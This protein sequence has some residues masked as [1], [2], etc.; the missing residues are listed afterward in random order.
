MPNFSGET[1]STELLKR[2][3]SLAPWAAALDIIWVALV[4]ATLFSPYLA[5]HPILRIGLSTYTVAYS[6]IVVYLFLSTAR[7][8]G[9]AWNWWLPTRR[10]H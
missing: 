4:L 3:K 10:D 7:K 9:L 2:R 1:V 8:L 6:A 5:S